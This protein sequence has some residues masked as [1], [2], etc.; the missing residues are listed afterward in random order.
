MW[1]ISASLSADNLAT[2]PLLFAVLLEGIAREACEGAASS[3]SESASDSGPELDSELLASTSDVSPYCNTNGWLQT[4][5]AY[6]RAL[7]ATMLL[8]HSSFETFSLRP[9][10]IDFL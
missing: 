10:Y 3:I 4:P 1:I 2:M 6:V 9:I 5:Q 7:Q 8:T